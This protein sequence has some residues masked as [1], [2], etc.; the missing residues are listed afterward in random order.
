VGLLVGAALSLILRLL[1]EMLERWLG[2]PF[3]AVF[4]I[5][6]DALRYR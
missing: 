5:F 2:V 6:V 4:M 1:K 3:S